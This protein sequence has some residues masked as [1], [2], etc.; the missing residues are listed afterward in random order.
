MGPISRR[1]STRRPRSKR[2]RF[3]SPPGRTSSPC[4]ETAH[5]RCVIGVASGAGDLKPA[6]RLG[7]RPGE[8]RVPVALVGPRLL[9]GG[10]RP[11]AIAL[12]DL[13]TT[14][15]TPGHATG[16]RPVAAAGAI[17]GKALAPLESGRGLIPVVLT[18]QVAMATLSVRQIA[19]T[20][21][22]KTG[23]LSVNSDVYGYIFRE[24][25]DRSS[26]RS[27]ASTRPQPPAAHPLPPPTP[28]D[29]LG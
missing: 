14:S 1:S 16:R 4:P 18:L 23:D 24:D 2:A 8:P 21:L 20:C 9:Q 15:D 27:A 22:G 17:M 11:G 25:G 7:A 19:Q 13:L 29:D 5:D 3:S 12:G 28:R 10:R 26:A 6:L